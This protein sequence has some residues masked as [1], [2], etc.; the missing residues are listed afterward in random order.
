M[1]PFLFLKRRNFEMEDKDPDQLG[2]ENEV[3]GAEC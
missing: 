3:E 2:F 1:L